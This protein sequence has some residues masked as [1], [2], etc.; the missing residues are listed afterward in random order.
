MPAF[1]SVSVAL[2]ARISRYNLNVLAGGRRRDL[3]DRRARRDRRAPARRYAHIDRPPEAARREP[4]AAQVHRRRRRARG[5]QRQDL[6]APGTRSRR[7]RR[8]RAAT[9]CSARKAQVDTKPQLEIFADD[10]KCA[11]GA[12]V[13]R[14]DDDAVFYLRAAGS[15]TRRRATCSPTR[16]APRSSIAYRSPRSGSG[17]R[18][19]CSTRRRASHDRPPDRA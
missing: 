16:S 10:V 4:P 17:S 12:T 18:Q 13:G 19:P 8:S 5:V 3:H 6:R 11:H 9:C 1:D 14:L 15:P 2:G 7:T